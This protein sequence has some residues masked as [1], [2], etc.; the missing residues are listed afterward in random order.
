MWEALNNVAA[1]TTSPTTATALYRRSLYTFW[2]RTAPPPNMMAFDAPT[3]ELCTVAPRPTNT[4]LKPLVLLND[5][6]FVEAARALGR[7]H[8]ARRRRHRRDAARAGSSARRRPRIPTARERAGPARALRRAARAIRRR[9]RRAPS[10]ARKSATSLRTRAS[11]PPSSPPPR[12]LPAPSSISTPAS[13]TAERHEPTSTQLFSH[14]RHFF[15]RRQSSASA[16]SALASHAAALLGRGSAGGVGRRAESRT[17]PPKAK[18]VIYLFMSGGPSQQDLFDYKPL[19][20]ELNGQ[21]LPD[22]RPRRQRLTGMT[23]NQASLPLAGSLF[24]FAQHGKAARGSASCCRT[25]PDRRRPLLRQDHVHRG[26]QPR[27]GDHVLPDRLADRRP[28]EHGRRG[29]ATASAAMNDDLPAFVVLRRRQGPRRDQPLYARLWGSGFLPS[30]APGRAVPRRQATRCSTSP[31]P[32]ASARRAARAMLDELAELNRA[33]SSTSRARPRDRHAHRAVRDGLP[34]ADERARADRPVERAAERRSTSTA[35]TPTKPGTFAANCLLARR[36]AERGVRFIQLYHR[37]WDHHGDL[38]DGIRRPV[39]GRRPGR[40]PR[41]IT[42]L[43]QRGLLDDTLV[44][45][46]GEFGRTVYSQGKLTATDYGRDHHP[47]CF[48]I[49]LA[50]GGVK[51]GIDLRR[52]RRLRLQHR[53]RTPSTSTTCTPRSSTSSASTTNGSPTNSK[54]AL[55]PDRRARA[56][57]EGTHRVSHATPRRPSCEGSSPEGA[58]VERRGR[59]LVKSCIPAASQANA[60]EGTRTPKDCSTRS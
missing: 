25:S 1:R 18:R 55:P 51:A 56:R 35:P 28:A 52:D 45:W 50:G 44:V 30:E 42:D 16:A 38:P 46:G 21:Q 6:Q 22:P 57:R 60:E 5:A 13:S 11:R 4:P 37:G 32:T 17:S 33:C 2:K 58:L 3:R 27:P 24:K 14:R 54:A 12:P 9:R 40:A 47:R 26:D 41:S 20:S 31:I 7:A 29:S 34:H 43:K 8:A 48:T 49:W 19:L 23:A 36:L 53:R 15:S 10:S 59:M 39:Q